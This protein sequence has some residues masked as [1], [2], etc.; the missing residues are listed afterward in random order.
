VTI[1]K[2]DLFGDGVHGLMVC[3]SQRPVQYKRIGESL[4]GSPAFAVCGK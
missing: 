2:M 3:V 1:T 4:P